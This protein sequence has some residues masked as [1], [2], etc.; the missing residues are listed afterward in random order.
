M[1]LFELAK[2]QMYLPGVRVFTCTQGSQIPVVAN[3][4]K[5]HTEC[6]SFQLK[7]PQRSPNVTR[8]RP[9]SLVTSQ[10]TRAC[11]WRAGLCNNWLIFCWPGSRSVPKATGSD[12]VWSSIIGTVG[13]L[14]WRLWIWNSSIFQ[15]LR[16]RTHPR[17][18]DLFKKKKSCLGTGPYP[19][20]A[21][22]NIPSTHV[23]PITWRPLGAPKAEHPNSMPSIDA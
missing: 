23:L 10:L 12:L 4:H 7:L 14:P 19:L 16:A 22:C 8:L 18:G 1:T 13:G 20:Q 6:F 17:A 15:T 2:G 5:M 11:G 21:C 9:D 3:F